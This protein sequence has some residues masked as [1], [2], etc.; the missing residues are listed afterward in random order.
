[1]TTATNI[2]ATF[3]D[4]IDAENRIASKTK[5]NTNAITSAMKAANALASSEYADEIEQEIDKASDVPLD[6]DRV[7]QL[8]Q[9]IMNSSVDPITAWKAIRS[10]SDNPAEYK[11]L[12]KILDKD[13]AKSKE[14]NDWVN[15]T[16]NPT[17]TGKKKQA[18][19]VAAKPQD[20]DALNADDALAS[21]SD[22][23]NDDDPFDLTDDP[24]NLD[25]LSVDDTMRTSVEPTQPVEETPA[26][27][28][29]TEETKKEETTPIKPINDNDENGDVNPGQIEVKPVTPPKP[30]APA[31]APTPAPAPAPTPTSIVKPANRAPIRKPITIDELKTKPAKPVA[32]PVHDEPQPKVPDIP[33][34]PNETESTDFRTE[35]SDVYDEID[36]RAISAEQAEE[37]KSYAD[38]VFS[39]P[40][41]DDRAYAALTSGPSKFRTSCI[42]GL[43]TTAN[44]HLGYKADK[45]TVANNRLNFSAGMSSQEKNNKSI[46]K[47]L[48]MPSGFGM[49]RNAA[50]WNTPIITDFG[51]PFLNFSSDAL[52]SILSSNN[53]ERL[54][55]GKLKDMF[56]EA[57][58]RLGGIW[59]A[60]Y[61]A[62]TTV[63]QQIAKDLGTRC[64]PNY[65][66]VD[67]NDLISS[68]SGER[69]MVE[70]ID[71]YGI[72]P[73]FLGA[74]AVPHDFLTTFYDVIDYSSTSRSTYL[75]F[76]DGMSPDDFADEI[77][78]NNGI[79]P[80]YILVPKSAKFSKC[81][82]RSGS[83]LGSLLD[84]ILGRQKC[85]MV[86]TIFQ[87]KKGCLVME[88]SIADKLYSDI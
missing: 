79:P 25:S 26:P 7:Y 39:D 52:T 34:E 19:P 58:K 66:K 56:K 23:I 9:L 85:T 51:F 27:A 73:S 33:D 46:N 32:Q 64:T 28:T 57:S 41:L 55:N 48:I 3:K 67:G 38:Q 86:K 80:F 20:D 43:L 17:G 18:K 78:E 45:A 53:D 61:S 10:T 49:K 77:N 70:P 5:Y 11:K 54:K 63:L 68:E 22:L 4:F 59:K 47:Q 8:F 88:S 76:A 6:D 44:R 84:V 75:K 60:I 87:K 36:K 30:A 13:G 21:L 69:I 72:K 62:P 29:S 24:F 65:L 15:K 37:A 50:V 2:A 35:F 40:H 81:K 14:L 31:P 71:Y 83:V 74:V 42:A 12:V 16:I 1:M 82:V